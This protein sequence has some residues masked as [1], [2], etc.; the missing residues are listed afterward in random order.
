MKQR[1]FSTT[2]TA[3]FL[4]K[5]NKQLSAT[6]PKEHRTEILHKPIGTADV[7]K[8]TDNSPVDSRGIIQRF[9]DFMDPVK[10]KER[11]EELEKEMARSGMYDVYIYRKTKG[12]IFYSPP[13]YWK[14]E[15]ALYMPNLVGEDL[16]SSKLKGTTSVL[17]GKVSIVRIFTSQVGEKQSQSFFKL[18]DQDYLTP[19]GYEEFLSA[20]PNSQI[21]DI[22]ITENAIKALS[23]KISKSGIRKITNSSRHDKY[24]IVP[25]KGLDMK[26]KESIQLLNT[27]TGFIYVIDHEGRIR[28]AACGDASEKERNMLWRT[29]RGLETEYRALNQSKE[30]P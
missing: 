19:K 4:G 24:F 9:K 13:S 14:A 22:N 25:K 29:V 11:Q 2:P 8:D 18:S 23:V 16:L 12:K 15:K 3:Q 30:E 5:L 1:C 28:W 26:L 7:P 10:N 17:K 6:A 21:V 27:Y 20:H